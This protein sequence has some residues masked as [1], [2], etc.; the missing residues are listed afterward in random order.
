MN[1]IGDVIPKIERALA[2]VGPE[3]AE[4][5]D[6]AMD[7][8]FEEHFFFQQTQAEA[9]ASGRI[10]TEEALAIYAALG[11]VWSSENGGWAAGTDT[12]T[13]CA[14]TQAMGELLSLVPR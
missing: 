12:A 9:H 11:E 2:D 4:E 5:L 13:K 6:A 3:K 10:S 1:R 8:G 14:V 7:V